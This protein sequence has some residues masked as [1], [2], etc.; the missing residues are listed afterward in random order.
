MPVGSLGTQACHPPR[1]VRW[2]DQEIVGGYSGR[3]RAAYLAG[4]RELLRLERLSSEPCEVEQ[5]EPA[6]ERE[7]S[8]TL[9][10]VPNINGVY[11]RLRVSGLE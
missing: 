5:C 8:R 7:S 3:N 1:R 6:E 9:P 2:S 11:F 10:A 4:C